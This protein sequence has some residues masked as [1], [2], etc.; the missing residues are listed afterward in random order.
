MPIY[1]LKCDK[2][3]HKT[4]VYL[5]N[6]ESI[7]SFECS[8]CGVMGFWEKLPTVPL[9]PKDGTYSWREKK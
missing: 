5:H 2:C 1:C 8:E 4:E 7:K 6:E 9:I 3:D